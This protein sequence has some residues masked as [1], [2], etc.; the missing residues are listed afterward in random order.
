ME[1]DSHAQYARLL[2]TNWFYRKNCTR[3]DDS[4]AP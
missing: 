2:E 3:D 1:F 4:R